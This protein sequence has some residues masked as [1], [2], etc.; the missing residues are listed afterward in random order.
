MYQVEETQDCC[1][2]EQYL[3]PFVR[4]YAMIAKVTKVLR[5]FQRQRL[6]RNVDLAE[7][8]SLQTSWHCFLNFA[9]PDGRRENFQSFQADYDGDYR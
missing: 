9:L 7:E 6:V 5:N 4:L 2:G 3:C 8:T 1:L